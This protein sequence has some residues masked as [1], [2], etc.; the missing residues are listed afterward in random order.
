MDFRNDG[1]YEVWEA[2]SGRTVFVTD[3]F[4]LALFVFHFIRGVTN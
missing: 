1:K 3:N 4:E 2:G